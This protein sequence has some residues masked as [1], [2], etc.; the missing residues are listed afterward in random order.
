MQGRRAGPATGA[1]ARRQPRS[2]TWTAE[3][4]RGERASRQAAAMPGDLL[5]HRRRERV[6]GG[7]PARQMP[8][9]GAAPAGTTSAARRPG[10][11]LQRRPVA[12]DAAT[13]PSKP[14]RTAAR[15]GSGGPASTSA[16]A[17]PRPRGGLPRRR[18]G[19]AW[20]P[21]R[22]PP[23]AC[24][25][26]GRSR[27]AAT[28]RS[29]TGACGGR[30]TRRTTAPTAALGARPG[31][32]APGLG[33]KARRPARRATGERTQPRKLRTGGLGG[34]GRA[35]LP[36]PRKLGSGPPP[37]PPPAAEA[38]RPARARRR[39]AGRARRCAAA[40]AP[41]RRESGRPTRRAPRRARRARET[42]A[43]TLWP[44]ARARCGPPSASALSGA[45]RPSPARGCRT[46]AGS[47]RWR[48]RGRAHRAGRPATRTPRRS[49]G[50]SGSPR[51]RRQVRAR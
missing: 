3:V 29:L 46:P 48:P 11:G 47:P 25:A 13:P 10:A 14:R 23:V 12:E 19:A 4:G 38:L 27:A 20:L 50:S 2:W 37:G 41:E 45:A 39:G 7:A 17:G 49:S 36:R 9:R 16:W 43:Q 33:E 15:S 51:G 34:W 40:S 18:P 6:P 5:P 42:A 24:G 32:A 1:G 31:R 21:A 44:G 22:A 35:P 28:H 26:T 8:R 30:A